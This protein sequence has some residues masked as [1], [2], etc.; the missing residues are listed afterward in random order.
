MDDFE[1]GALEMQRVAAEAMD[2][3]VAQTDVALSRCSYGIDYAHTV[4]R[5]KERRVHYAQAAKII[6]SIR[7]QPELVT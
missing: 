6:R 3:L 4:S 7:I 2:A 5:L 1:R